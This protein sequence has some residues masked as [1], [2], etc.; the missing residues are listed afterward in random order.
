M[1]Y[2]TVTESNI[3]IAKK[4]NQDSVLV[5]HAICGDNE[6]LMAVVCDG[7]GGLS[8]GE[9]A[10]AAVIRE[11]DDWFIK[12]LPHE[13]KKFDANVVGGKWSLMLKNLNARIQEYGQEFGE[14]MGTTF[15]GVLFVNDQFVAV[16]V[17]D[18]R[19][20]HIG[21]SARQITED[22][23][24][25]A[26]EISHGRLTPEQAKKDKRRHTLLQCVGASKSMEPQI[27][28]EE[29]NQGQYLLC[30][31]GFRNRLTE[32]ELAESFGIREVKNDGQM[33]RKVKQLI[34][35]VRGRGEKDDISV[36][37]I[38]ANIEEDSV[39]ADWADGRKKGFHGKRYR[40]LGIGCLGVSIVM[41][42]LGLLGI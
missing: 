32:E 33:K 17:G 14:K 4:T 24:Y 35:L 37:L 18:T 12:E 6:I 26:R 25:V 41:L 28:C 21:E 3:G 5:K 39:N 2:V 19:L 7:M 20:Y 31:D 22:H 11:F 16:H 23:T 10:S 15:T 38:R 34:E 8:K 36:I 1:R 42:V 40:L 13:L 29:V 27:V 9:I 30:S